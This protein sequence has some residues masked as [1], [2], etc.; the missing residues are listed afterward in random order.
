MLSS[1]E[2]IQASLVNTHLY[3]GSRLYMKL[4][5]QKLTIFTNNR[6]QARLQTTL[7]INTIMATTM[8]E[9]KQATCSPI[10][11]STSLK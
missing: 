1:I 7:S 2:A 4:K 9:C 6:L 5:I 3:G 10:T 11:G 8:I